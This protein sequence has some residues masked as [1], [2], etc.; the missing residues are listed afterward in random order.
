MTAPTPSAETEM[1][2]CAHC[3]QKAPLTG[4]SPRP[5]SPTAPADER[6]YPCSRCGTMR[7]K[8]E[9]GTT[10][11]VCDECYDAAHSPVA[12][13]ADFRELLDA[14]IDK[15]VRVENCEC[16]SMP[17]EH[18]IEYR[19]SRKALEDYEARIRAEHQREVKAM[20][21]MFGEVCEPLHDCCQRHKLGLGG[22]HVQH[23]VVE[24]VDRLSAELSSLRDSQLTERERI[25]AILRLEHALRES[26]NCE[27]CLAT[28]AKLRR[29]AGAPREGK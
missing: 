22:E 7:S 16:E 19:A 6:I 25:H 21:K 8:A 13:T 2:T 28:I 4:H 5:V 23:L 20:N 27:Y 17:C 9:G 18:V 11:T 14:L 29:L 3:G 15:S 10:F 12:P 24:E 1:R 26:P